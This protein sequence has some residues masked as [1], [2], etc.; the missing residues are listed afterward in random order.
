MGRLYSLEVEL[1]IDLW[2]ILLPKNSKENAMILA[3]IAFSWKYTMSQSLHSRFLHSIFSFLSILVYTL[4]IHLFFLLFLPV[5]LWKRWRWGK[6]QKSLGLRLGI[7]QPDLQKKAPFLIW[8]HAVSLGETRAVIPLVRRL[9]EQ[10]PEAEWVFSSATETGQREACRQFPF[11]RECIFLPLDFPYLIRP[12]VRQA[13]PDLLLITETD[14]WFHFQDEA[15]KQGARVCL[16]NGKLSSKSARWLSKVPWISRLLLG[17]VDVFCVQ[18]EEYKRRFLTLGVPEGSIEVTGNLK[19]DLNWPILSEQDL[20]VLKRHWGL[21]REGLILT[22][23]STHETE[24]ELI[25]DQ[26]PRLREAF[27]HLKIFLVPRHPERFNKVAQLLEQR[28]CSFIRWSAFS[29]SSEFMDSWESKESRPSIILVDVMGQLLSCYQLSDLAIVAGSFLNSVG[30]HNILEPCAY[31]VPVLFGPYMHQQQELRELVLCSGAGRQ[32]SRDELGITVHQL[33]QN[34]SQRD[35][36]GKAGLQ[37]ITS[38]KG[39]AQKTAQRVLLQKKEENRK[40][41][42]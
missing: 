4:A 29:E 9:R 20:Q 35:T 7:R 16:V 24:E 41:T 32:V 12:L 33:L 34:A 13:Q 39:S 3:A 37:L 5:L 26:L 21:Q 15:K 31:G 42:K 30:G 14:F 36:M 11:A 28:A 2:N 18:T 40:K 27:P 23:G 19:F 6:Y 17:T 8:V 1:A 10:M 22:V 38:M 25:L